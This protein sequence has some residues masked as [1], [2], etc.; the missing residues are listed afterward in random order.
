MQRFARF[1]GELRRRGQIIPDPD[2]RIAATAI[3]HGLTLVTRNRRNRRNRRDFDR[4]P[5]L[6]LFEP[7]NG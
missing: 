7:G 3:E 4:I 2:L 5:G 6:A 1:R